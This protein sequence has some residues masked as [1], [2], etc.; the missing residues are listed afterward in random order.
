M[1]WEEASGRATLHTW[2][3]VHL[4]P[5]TGRVPYLAAVADLG[6]GPRMMTELVYCPEDGPRAGMPLEVA[7]RDGVPVFRPGPGLAAGPAG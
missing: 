7:F 6:E 5:F 4:P 1:A 2:S 3:A